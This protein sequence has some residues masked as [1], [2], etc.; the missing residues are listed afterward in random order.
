MAKMLVATDDSALAALLQGVLEGL[1]HAVVWVLDG[2]EALEAALDGAEAV[3][4]DRNLAIFHGLETARLLHEDP[5]IPEHLPVVILSDDPVEPHQ[6]DQAGVT[7]VLS[8][9]PTLHELQEL[10]SQWAWE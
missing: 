2:R 3:F 10:T 8:K 6:C 4:L 7:A 9:S 1:G 5:D